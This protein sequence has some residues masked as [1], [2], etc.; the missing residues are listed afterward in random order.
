[1][2][3]IDRE[4]EVATPIDKAVIGKGI[5]YRLRQPEALGFVRAILHA[6][7]EGACRSHRGDHRLTIGLDADVGVLHRVQVDGCAIG[8]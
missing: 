7:D 3:I 1:M 2:L 6:V 4:V 8:M 5:D